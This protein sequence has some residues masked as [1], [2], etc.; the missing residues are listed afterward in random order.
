[1]SETATNLSPPEWSAQLRA[2]DVAKLHLLPEARQ[3]LLE[4]L[5]QAQAA[6]DL[7]AQSKALYA[8]GRLS[9]HSF[10]GGDLAEALSFYKEGLEL[11]QQTPDMALEA[12]LY[13]AVAT[14]SLQLGTYDQAVE[15]FSLGL[16]IAKRSEDKSIELLFSH[17]IAGFHA[18][19][20][21]YL[22]ALTEFK[23]ALTIAKEAHIEGYI[24][25][26]LM[27]LASIY[28]S[29]ERYQEALGVAAELKPYLATHPAMTVAL[30]EL[31]SQAFLGLGQAGAAWERAS[32]GLR[33]LEEDGDERLNKEKLSLLLNQAGAAMQLGRLEESGELLAQAAALA[34]QSQAEQLH[35][36][37][38]LACLKR[39][40]AE[41]L[42]LRGDHAAALHLLKGYVQLEHKIRE[43]SKAAQ[44]YSV[45]IY[46]RMQLLEREAQLERQRSEELLQ[47]NQT[48]RAAQSALEFQA[49]YD[50]LTGLC[51][52]SYFQ[53]L[54]AQALAEL[55]EGEQVALI[56][57]DIDN[58]KAVN[59]LYGHAAGDEL[60]RE[61]ASRLRGVARGQ[62][63]ARMGGDEFM[64]LQRGQ[65]DAT[66]TAYQILQA[67]AQPLALASGDVIE[68]TA[69]AGV[70]FA[71]DDSLD[72][73]LLQQQAD[74]A[75]YTT[76]RQQYNTVLR[77]SPELGTERENRLRLEKE[78]RGAVARGELELHY[79]GR[80][81]LSDRA[82]DGFEALVRWNHPRLGRLSPL[83]F[84]PLAEQTRLVLPLG[85]WVMRESCRQARAWGF[86]ERGLTMSFNVSALQFEDDD[87][88]QTV[89]DALTASG[90]IPARLLLEITETLI[91]RDLERAKI[92]IQQLHGLGVQV[93]MDDFGTGY[94][95]LSVLQTLP[96]NHLKIDRSFV[97]QVQQKSDPNNPARFVLETILRLA[98]RLDMQVTA[99]GVETAEQLELLGQLGCDHVQGYYLGRPQAAAQIE[100]EFELG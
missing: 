42:E 17:N 84:I 55:G 96:L 43:R 16:Q 83:A 50:A 23:K 63:V 22:Q 54:T 87:F 13:N 5:A 1:M 44:E 79:Q 91:L 9:Y 70:A 69:S 94:S 3:Q 95:S 51:N 45:S 53:H 20:G 56:F 4:W 27:N 71:P 58:F 72:A 38:T 25:I 65:H 32:E 26:I 86:N 77:Y 80:F 36:S 99:E 57:I 28:N 82:L 14:T 90:L 7:W 75:M 100:A 35:G 49:R 40:Q 68:I 24:L 46:G 48:L 62:L 67:L 88:V 6:G 29:L 89:Q 12:R 61:V 64:V 34:D 93:T 39:A 97:Q 37:R 60:L 73:T 11:A 41:L 59:D 31:E 47:A 52:R 74:L 76:K 19:S 85:N 10:N 78:L 98:H 66:Q 81:V 30:A 18:D 2:L 92:K 33:H 15:A 21:N 8:L